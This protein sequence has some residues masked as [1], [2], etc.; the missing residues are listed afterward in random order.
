LSLIFIFGLFSVT[1]L[2]VRTRW[3]HNTVTSSCSHTYYYYYYYYH[4]HHYYHHYQYYYYHYYYN[5][6]Y[7][8]QYSAL[9]SYFILNTFL[10]LRY[11]SIYHQYYLY[12]ARTQWSK[13]LEESKCQRQLRLD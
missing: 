9:A 8:Y 12:S 7:Y 11:N 3:F 5:N 10:L 4:H 1:S 2:S 6:Y 13:C